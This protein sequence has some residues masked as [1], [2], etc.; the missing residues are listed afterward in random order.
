MNRLFAKRPK[1]RLPAIVKLKRAV[2]R[3]GSDGTREGF[4]LAQRVFE[5][6]RE[7]RDA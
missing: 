4:K 7:L 2:L 1:G 3:I 6:A 5:A